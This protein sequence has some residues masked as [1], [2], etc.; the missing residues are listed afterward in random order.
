MPENYSP[1][2]GYRQRSRASRYV[3]VARNRFRPG[4]RNTLREKWPKLRNP[5]RRNKERARE[6]LL[7]RKKAQNRNS[8]LGCLSVLRVGRLE[9]ERPNP[10]NQA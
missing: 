10:T 7:R 9:E 3:P 1:L 8:L 2:P 5:L 4:Q 6:E